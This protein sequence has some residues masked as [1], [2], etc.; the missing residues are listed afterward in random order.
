M[1]QL[2]NCNIEYK[3]QISALKHDLRQYKGHI[4]SLSMKLSTNKNK[5]LEAKYMFNWRVRKEQV[6]RQV[7]LS[8]PWLTNDPSHRHGFSV[9]ARRSPTSSTRR[10]SCAKHSTAGSTVWKCRGRTGTTPRLRGKRS[11]CASNWS[12]STRSRSSR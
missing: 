11:R 10:I 3:N 12:A 1:V 8:H 7:C 6:D 2:R 9:S 5:F 4:K